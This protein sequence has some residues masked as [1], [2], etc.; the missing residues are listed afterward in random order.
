MNKCWNSPQRKILAD[1]DAAYRH[2]RTLIL[3]FD[4]DG[5]LA[6]IAGHPRL[7]RLPSGTRS[8]LERLARYP[9]VRVGVLS[10]RAIDDLHTMVGLRNVYYVGTSGLEL[11]LGARQLTHPC[12]AEMQAVVE[13][14]VRKLEPLIADYQRAWIEWKRLGCTVHYRDVVEHRQDEL[15]RRL[16]A[17]AASFGCGLRCVAGPRAVEI[18]PASAWT[19]GTAV[20]MILGAE[21][22]A[23]CFP[24]YAGDSDNDTEALEATGLVG[25]ISVGVGPCAPPAQYRLPDPAALASL[26]V[27]LA[28]HLDPATRPTRRSAEEYLAVCDIWRT[29]VPRLFP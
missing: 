23:N 8:S 20:N 12:A 28:D 15:R 17:A 6:P 16:Q 7:A 1:L 24:L 27:R 18:V 29:S 21:K 2:G 26:L 25:G 22:D 14:M 4:Y 19:K 13:E 3:L 11:H 9:R 5:T 10:G